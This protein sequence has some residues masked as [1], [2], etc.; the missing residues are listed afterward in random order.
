MVFLCSSSPPATVCNP[1]PAT[2]HNAVSIKL[3]HYGESD[4][5]VGHWHAMQSPHAREQAE[6]ELVFPG[7]EERRTTTVRDPW[8]V[9]ITFQ[10]WYVLS[11]QAC[12]VSECAFA[13]PIATVAMS[14]AM[15]VIPQ[16]E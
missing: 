3:S 6:T 14:M 8:A 12:W 15:P 16:G 9:A 2:H 5:G 1:Q 4:P 13:A 7:Y 10:K 11:S